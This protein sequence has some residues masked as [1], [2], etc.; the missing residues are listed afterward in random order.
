MSPLALGC[1]G[2]N[3]AR[4]SAR[5][6]P[7]MVAT[8]RVSAQVLAAVCSHLRPLPAASSRLEPLGAAWSR[9]EP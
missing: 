3:R 2:R 9:L 5:T 6:C 4:R 7:H 8:S 1:R